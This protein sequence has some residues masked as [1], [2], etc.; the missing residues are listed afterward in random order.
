MR[1]IK[2]GGLTFVAVLLCLGVPQAVRA[3]PIDDYV[4]AEITRQNVPGLS[5]AVIRNGQLMRA[6]GY[7]LANLEHHVPVHPDTLFK[8]GAVGMQFTAVAVMQLVED[9]KIGLDDPIRKYFPDSPVSWGPITIRNLLN[10]TSG[11][12]TTP[13]GNF[14]TEYT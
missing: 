6:N 9:G 7:G 13:N 8:T 11:L 12:P 1:K 3:D 10:H 5:L 2:S 14:R 4:N